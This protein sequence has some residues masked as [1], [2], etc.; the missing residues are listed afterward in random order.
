MDLESNQY[1]QSRDGNLYVGTTRITVETVIVFWQH[2]GRTP[3]QIH[4]SFPHVPLFAVYGT[5]ACYLEHKDAVDAF[6]RETEELDAARWAA[7]QAAHP[8]FYAEMRRRFADLRARTSE[9]TPAG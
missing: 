3:E 9:E 7:E 4:E 2:K 5:I 1:V 8:E 6:F